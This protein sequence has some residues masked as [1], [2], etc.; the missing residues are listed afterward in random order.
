MYNIN[1]HINVLFF[2]KTT[3]RSRECSASNNKNPTN[4]IKT[5]NSAYKEH[6]L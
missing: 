2:Q 4:L 5:T 6:V 1:N 3:G